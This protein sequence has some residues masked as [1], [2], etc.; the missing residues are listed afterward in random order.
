MRELRSAHSRFAALLCGLG[1]LGCASASSR[2]APPPGSPRAL[3]TSD[4][5]FQAVD[6]TSP[7]PTASDLPGYPL[8]QVLPSLARQIFAFSKDAFGYDGCET[9]LN[10]CLKQPAHQRHA[11]R[12]LSLAT[13]L[14]A[15]GATNVEID[16]ALNTYYAAFPPSARASLVV[17]DSMCRGPRDAKVTVVE[18]SD[19]ECPFCRMAR[20]LLEGLVTQGGS[21]RLCFRPYP[22]KMHPHA[23]LAAEAAMYA[24]S[25]G[26]FWELHDLLFEHQDS[27]ELADLQRYAADANL[28]PAQLAQAV[29]TQAFQAA[30]DASKQEGQDAKVTG[31]PSIFINGRSYDLPL[32]TENLLQAIDDELEWQQNGG[33]WAPN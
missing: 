4:A 8:D 19:F 12:M 17:D 6:E 3:R 16:T 11:L 1:L 33:H 26:K 13:R 21:V 9:A 18:F 22:L 5:G 24:R 31:T 27:L 14:A 20:P 29:Q 30:I 28:D 7:L 25:Q 23:Q 32:G 15:A 2:P 10:E